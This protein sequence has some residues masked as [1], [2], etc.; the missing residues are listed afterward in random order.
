MR[1]GNARN[2]LRVTLQSFWF[3]VAC[4]T[5]QAQGEVFFGDGFESL[6]VYSGVADTSDGAVS[7][8][9]GSDDLPVVAYG[10]ADGLWVYKCS[11]ANCEAGTVTHLDTTTGG[12]GG[13]ATHVVVEIGNDT[14]PVIALRNESSE[15]LMVVKCA[16]ASCA[17]GGE[18]GS[19]IAGVASPRA[20]SMKVPADGNPVIAFNDVSGTPQTLV[21]VK[22]DDPACSG[23]GESVNT[24]QDPGAVSNGGGVAFPF[25]NWGYGA[26]IALTAGGL[27]MVSYHTFEV[28]Y[29]LVM[30]NDAACAGDDE[31]YNGYRTVLSG[32]ATG[33]GTSLV[34]RADN[35]PMFSAYRQRSGFEDSQLLFITCN[36]CDISTGI[37]SGQAGLNSNISTVPGGF[38]VVAF[39]EGLDDSVYVAKCIDNSCS[40]QD[41]YRLGPEIPGPRAFSPDIEVPS[42]NFPIMVYRVE[43]QAFE[44]VKCRTTTCTS[45]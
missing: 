4:S 1:N 33:G 7:L 18:L 28:W 20:V 15:T 10:Q 21:V 8:A 27:P 2:T 42:D 22:C 45:S 12:G 19:L 3:L 5:A 23:E 9:I 39:T 26:S 24:I 36:P 35:F 41:R 14:F 30:C 34:L 17:G 25:T 43:G 40:I 16:D 31:S 32:Y 38:P 44:I 29:R 11:D 37:F 6:L 13:P